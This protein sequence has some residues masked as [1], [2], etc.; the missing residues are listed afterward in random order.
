MKEDKQIDDATKV[1]KAL[2]ETMQKVFNESQDKPFQYAVAYKRVSD[3]TVIGYHASTWCNLVDDR[4]QAKRYNGDNSFEQ[5][6]IIHRNI[7]SVLAVTDENIYMFD[8]VKRQVKTKFFEGIK[9]EDIYLEADY[10]EDDV[11]KQTFV[12]GQIQ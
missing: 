1:A 3:D 11:P 8:G 12:F 4:L 10:L 6:A 2:K 7:T 5:L 9:I